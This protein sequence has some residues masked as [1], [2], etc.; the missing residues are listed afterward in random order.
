LPGRN[1]FPRSL[2][3]KSRVEITGLLNEGQ[4]FT[5]N[6]FTLIWRPAGQFGWCV[7]VSKKFGKAADRV[8]IKRRFREAIRLYRRDMNATG[9]LAVL[10]KPGS[11]KQSFES[12][13][14]DV[15]RLVTELR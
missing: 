15:K 2:S 4:R 12:I 8:R 3:L 6:C 5:G 9:Q 10:P 1:N 13:K 14:A 7:L 11:L